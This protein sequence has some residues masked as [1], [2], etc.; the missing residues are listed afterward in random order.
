VAAIPVLLSPDPAVTSVTVD[1]RRR[2]ACLNSS[3]SGDGIDFLLMHR[4]KR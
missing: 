4:M 3:D 1:A 2:I